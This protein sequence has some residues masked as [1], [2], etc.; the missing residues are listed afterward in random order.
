MNH[1]EIAIHNLLHQEPMV[2]LEVMIRQEPKR[3]RLEETLTQVMNH[4]EPPHQEQITKGMKP[5]QGLILVKPINRLVP[6]S[7]DPMH[8]ERHQTQEITQADK[9]KHQAKETAHKEMKVAQE[10]TEGVNC[11]NSFYL[12][13]KDIA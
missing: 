10:V 2:L 9:E 3:F 5:L 6:V 4:L 12:L 7:P 11:M 1:Q 8:Q 13:E